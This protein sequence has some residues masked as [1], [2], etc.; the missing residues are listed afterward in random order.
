MKASHGHCE[1]ATCACG[2]TIPCAAEQARRPGMVGRLLVPVQ[3]R[4]EHA[5][6]PHRV[7]PEE[8]VGLREIVERGLDLAQH[9]LDVLAGQELEVRPDPPEHRDAPRHLAVERVRLDGEHLDGRRVG[10]V[11][12]GPRPLHRLRRATH[13]STQPSTRPIG[14]PG[15]DLFA[16]NSPSG[17]RLQITSKTQPPR[18]G[19]PRSSCPGHSAGSACRRAAG[20]RACRRRRRTLVHDRL[21]HEIPAQPTPARFSAAATANCATRPPF[22]SQ[23]PRP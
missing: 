21:A 19:S 1:A 20:P 18:R 2:P 16:G 3:R 9:R 14:T 10:E 7:T 15:S 11:R 17:P 8:G 4:V 5:L 22:M 23:L 6:E 13:P 12:V